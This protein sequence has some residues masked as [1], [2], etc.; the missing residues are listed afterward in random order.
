MGRKWKTYGAESFGENIILDGRSSDFSRHFLELSYVIYAK[1][2]REKSVKVLH[3]K[4]LEC[5]LFYQKELIKRGM[6][7]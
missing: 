4:A 6:L 3:C 5:M 1:Y 2:M 7:L